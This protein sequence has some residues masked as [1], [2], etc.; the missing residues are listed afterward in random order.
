M[1][2]VVYL[3]LLFI[4]VFSCKEEKPK[5]WIDQERLSNRAAED[6]LTLGG[7][8]QMQHYSPLNQINASNVQD[9]GFAW[10]YDAT[11]I[12]GNSYVQTSI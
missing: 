9:L 4:S 2:K 7:N 6:W 10:E 1:R 8:E 12:I 3:F 11:T 5:G